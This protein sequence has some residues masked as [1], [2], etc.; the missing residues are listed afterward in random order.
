M[1]IKVY[2]ASSSG[3]IAVK[4]HQQAVVG[5]LEANRINFQEVDITMLEEQRLWMYRNIPKEKKPEKG[6]PL[7]P[8]IF[9]EDR[10]CGDYEDFFQSKENNTVFAF[11][12][13]SSPLKF[14][15]LD[16][17]HLYTCIT[18]CIASPPFS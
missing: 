5:F 17:A 1:V 14:R 10:Y 8:Q 18:S 15:V 12:G 3:S 6:N 11:L 7:P 2:V 16:Q 9:N 4:K 13:L